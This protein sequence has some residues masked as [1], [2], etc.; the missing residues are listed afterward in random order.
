[1]LWA[2][3]AQTHGLYLE[4]RWGSVRCGFRGSAGARGP[5]AGRFV[6]AVRPELSLHPTRQQPSSLE[7]QQGDGGAAER[8]A[9]MRQER[10][11]RPDASAARCHNKSSALRL[12]QQ[13]VNK[14]LKPVPRPAARRDVSAQSPLQ[15]L[16]LQ[17]CV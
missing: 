14:S 10:G 7:Q 16:P 8:S 5:A 17:H 15:R 4:K 1:M 11:K 2:E 6:C 12:K 3:P 13:H 9:S